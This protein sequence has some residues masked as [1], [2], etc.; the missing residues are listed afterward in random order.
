MN[1]KCIVVGWLQENC[2]IITKNNDAIIVDPGDEFDK[3][4]TN[5]SNYNIKAV[6]I[7][8]YHDDHIGALDSVVNKYNVPIFDYKS[9]NKN[10]KIGDFDFEII[11][12]KG[13]TDDSVTFYFTKDKVMFTGDFLFKDSIGR[14]DFPNSSYEDML[15]SIEKIKMYPLDVTIYPGHGEHS[16]LGYEVQNNIFLA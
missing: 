15:K 6:L 3:I 2:Y 10:V 8:H 12:T 1:I 11:D 9:V 5:L 14:Y 13:H 7:T 16:N 4:E